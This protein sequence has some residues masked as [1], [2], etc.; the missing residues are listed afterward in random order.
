MIRLMPLVWMSY[1]DQHQP[2]QSKSHGMIWN[3]MERTKAQNA[4]RLKFLA[5]KGELRCFLWAVEPCRQVESSS[6]VSACSFPGS[7][8]LAAE[9][10]KC[11]IVCRTTSDG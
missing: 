11:P 8:F 5:V 4:F 10:H 2:L 3:D 1:Q 7:R 9:I 6:F